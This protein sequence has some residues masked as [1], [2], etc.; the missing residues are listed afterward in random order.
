MRRG[1]QVVLAALV[2]LIA[3]A[4]V[5]G[6]QR[7]VWVGSAAALAAAGAV[8]ASLLGLL[9]RPTVGL[10]GALALLLFCGFAAWVGVSILWSA[11]PDRSWSSFNRSLIYLAFLGLGLVAGRRHLGDALAGLL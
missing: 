4:F 11:A 2:L 9:P 8:G 6:E 3:A 1:D 7:L 10:E 5:A